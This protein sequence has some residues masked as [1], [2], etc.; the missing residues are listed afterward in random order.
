[1]RI[2][3]ASLTLVLYL[4]FAG[5]CPASPNKR[6][7]KRLDG[8]AIATAGFDGTVRLFDTKT[9]DL[10]KQFVPVPIGEPKQPETRPTA[11]AAR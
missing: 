8:S 9:G 4:Y 3:S 1:M 10:V 5:Q 7:I 2:I 6:K 11:T